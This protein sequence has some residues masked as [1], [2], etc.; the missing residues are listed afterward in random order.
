M[1]ETINV[2]P[3]KGLKVQKNFKETNFKVIHIK[4]EGERVPNTK[5]YRRLIKRGELIELK[6]EKV[7]KT[8][9]KNGS[10]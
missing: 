6:P 9:K 4:D 10:K 3:K 1:N 2:K 5:Y 7:T 8:V